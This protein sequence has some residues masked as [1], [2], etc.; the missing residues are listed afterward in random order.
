MSW[1]CQESNHFDSQ[2]R[3]DQ[4]FASLYIH[5][6]AT[7]LPC[8]SETTQKAQAS[9]ASVLTGGA[10]QRKKWPARRWLQCFPSACCLFYPPWRGVR[11]DKAAS[12]SAWRNACQWAWWGPKHARS[13]TRHAGKQDFLGNP[14]EDWSSLKDWQVG[15]TDQLILL[16]SLHSDFKNDSF[17]FSW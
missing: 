4:P 16:P 2:R 13:V 7:P 14:R 11:L 5:H 8:C 12:V 15:G 9:K 17:F 6:L 3:N 10:Q 1:P